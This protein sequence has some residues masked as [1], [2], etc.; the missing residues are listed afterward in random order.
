MNELWS[1]ILKQLS[2][3][4][5]ETAMKTWFAECEFVALQEESLVI[6][7]G[8]EFRRDIIEKRFSPIIREIAS[9]I[10][11]SEINLIVLGDAEEAQRYLGEGRFNKGDSLPVI[12]E[13]TFDRFVVGEANR[14][15][16]SVA[17]KVAENPKGNLLNPFYI[18]SDSGMGK[19]H[20]LYAIGQA[21][22]A[23]CPDKKVVYAKGSD[24]LNRMIEAIRNNETESFRQIYRQADVLLVDDIHIIA[25]KQAT[26]EEF[27]NTFNSIYEAG[28]QIVITCDRPPK[29]LQNLENRLLSRFES[30]IICEICPPELALRKDIIRDK[31]GRMNLDLE[32][33]D[34]E[35]IAS[36]LTKNVRQI[37][38]ALKNMAAYRE[39]TGKLTAEHMIRAVE[40]VSANTQASVTPADVIRETARYYAVTADDIRGNSREKKYVRARQVA[41]YLMRDKLGMTLVE[42]GKEMGNRNHATIMS[43]IRRINEAAAIDASMTIALRDIEMNMKNG[44]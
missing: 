5:S 30:G 38:G 23:A 27:F 31:A 1:E 16:A 7:A 25:G 6:C 17:K 12:E 13:F 19:T 33:P 3:T 39:I 41:I 8:N 44:A 2:S 22:M 4:L 24:F 26:Q 15:A 9:G 14:F 10:L 40:N 29:D 36:R 28:R 42:I 20:L 11:S 43:A 21:V 37:E 32:E 35:F 18:Y 34:V